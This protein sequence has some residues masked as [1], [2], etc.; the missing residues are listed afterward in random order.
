[1]YI[2]FYLRNFLNHPFPEFKF[3]FKIVIE[4]KELKYIKV[5]LRKKF[6]ATILMEQLQLLWNNYKSY[7]TIINSIVSSAI[8]GY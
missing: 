4:I 2:V 3:F 1:M 7:L 5:F 6:E 8:L